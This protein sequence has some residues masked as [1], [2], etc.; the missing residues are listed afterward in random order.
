MKLSAVVIAEGITTTSAGAWIRRYRSRCR[1]H[2]DPRAFTVPSLI[3]SQPDISARRRLKFPQRI[4]A[5]LGVV[6]E[7][8]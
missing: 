3:S 1:G 7:A 4:I 5:V 2:Y 6:L 8:T